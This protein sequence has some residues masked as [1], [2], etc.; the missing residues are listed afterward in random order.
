M[1]ALLWLPG[2][3][4]PASRA[5]VH[6][7]PKGP[8][9]PPFDVLD[10]HLDI[11][12]IQAVTPAGATRLAIHDD[13]VRLPVGAALRLELWQRLADGRV[14]LVT[15]DDRLVPFRL[16]TGPV[17]S[18]G[19]GRPEPG[20]TWFRLTPMR[21]LEPDHDYQLR[22]EGERNDQPT[23][24]SGKAFRDL[25]LTI[26]VVA[27]AGPDGGTGPDAGAAPTGH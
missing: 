19:G 24:D 13:A 16:E 3:H 23:D 21:P 11:V 12:A 5:T 22:I 8:P 25:A 26:H 17:A 10:D 2:C 4:R 14:R 18:R 7:A 9:P 6:A 15:P 20:G 27:A 1:A